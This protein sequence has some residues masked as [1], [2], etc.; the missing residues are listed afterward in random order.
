MKRLRRE[1]DVS[2][3]TFLFI[4]QGLFYAYIQ[5]YASSNRGNPCTANEYRKDTTNQSTAAATY[6]IRANNPQESP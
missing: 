3:R 1:P 5:R 2:K 6:S 4:I